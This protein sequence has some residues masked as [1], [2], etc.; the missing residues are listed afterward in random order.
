MTTECAATGTDPG[1]MLPG[2]LMRLV[3]DGLAGRGACVKYPDAPR[4][5][6]H[7]YKRTRRAGTI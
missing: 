2:E 3:G 5:A 4:R 6:A 7:D 1:G